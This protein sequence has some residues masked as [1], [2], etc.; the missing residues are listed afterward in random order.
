LERGLTPRAVER[1]R[2][3]LVAEADQVAVGP[4]S[5]RE[6][7]RADVQRLEQVRLAG[8]V[9]ADDEYDARRERE[10]QLRVGAVTAERD[11]VDDQRTIS[12]RGG[13]A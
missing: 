2:R 8:A 5:R 1:D 10:L 7:L 6:A 12:R 13:S 11:A 4:R 9:L 3:R